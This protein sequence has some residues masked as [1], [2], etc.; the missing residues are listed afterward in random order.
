MGLRAK[1]MVLEVAYEQ[2]KEFDLPL[3][4]EYKKYV[5][6]VG[7]KMAISVPSVKRSFKKWSILLHALRKHYPDL[8]KAPKPAPAPK[9]AAAPE[10]APA[11]PATWKRHEAA[12]INKES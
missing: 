5:E 11:K 12:Q 2:F 4:I 8:V 6:V 7:A 9:P 1:K 10:V 3:T